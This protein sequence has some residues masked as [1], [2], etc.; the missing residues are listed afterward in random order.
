MARKER[1][2]GL[3]I[4]IFS[5]VAT[6][7]AIQL[8]MG[9]ATKPGPGIFPLLL[10]LVIGLLSLLLILKNLRSR[11]RLGDRGIDKD[12]PTGKWRVVYLLGSLFLYV[13]LIQPIGFLIST[14]IFLIGLK[15]IIKKR[16]VPVLLGS[17][18][19]SVVLF[20]CFNYLLKVQLPMG[21]LA[22]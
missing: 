9:S 15:P 17:F 7:L 16:W 18:F 13:L 14:W 1:F 21:I 11:R 19:I 2:A 3:L 8:P 20:F 4:I 6:Y 22:K 12:V 10:G 5:G